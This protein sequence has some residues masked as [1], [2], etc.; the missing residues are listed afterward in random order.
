MTK[1]IDTVRAATSGLA[2]GAM[3]FGTALGSA[4]TAT[5]YAGSCTGPVGAG[6]VLQ[7]REFSLQDA[8]NGNS[9]VTLRV[10]AAMSESDAQLFVDRPGDKADFLLFG[11][12]KE[13]DDLLAQFKPERYSVSP[14]GLAMSGAI[15]VPNSTLD[16]DG[17]NGIAPGPP[18]DPEYFADRDGGRDEFYA[19]IRM[20]D[21]RNGSAHRVE[22]CRL[23]LSQ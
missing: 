13:S 6:N 10:D 23:S 17:L 7:V 19:D 11:D 1:T 3:V 18:V 8:G 22:T 5:A 20:G 21:I 14:A 4:A 16:E 2:V 15:Q 9:L 12:D